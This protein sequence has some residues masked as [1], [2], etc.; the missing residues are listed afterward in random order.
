MARTPFRKRATPSSAEARI[1]SAA[2]QGARRRGMTNREI[3]KRLGINERTVRKIVAGETSGRRIYR[4]RVTEIK[5]RPAT[6][7]VFR[8]D[9]RIGYDA[10]GKE[11]IRSVNVKLP[12]VPGPKGKRAPTFFDTLRL[13]DL[14]SVA[15]QEAEKMRNRY[16]EFVTREDAEAFIESLRP[17]YRRDPAKTLHT[18]RGEYGTT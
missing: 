4:K 8:A 1:E 7:N 12:D 15:K 2:I 17:I 11:I 10:D 9:V 18:I 6:P 5:E 3:A 14:Q 16:G 13:P